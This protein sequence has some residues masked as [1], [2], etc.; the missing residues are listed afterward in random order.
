MLMRKI[1]TLFFLF[2][3]S[4]SFAQPGDTIVITGNCWNTY[5]RSVIIGPTGKVTGLNIQKTDS[6]VFGSRRPW[7]CS[8]R[9]L[10]GNSMPLLI[11]DG[12]QT[13]IKFLSEIN[14]N[15]IKSVEILK[16]AQATAIFGPD[17]ANGALLIQT[18]QSFE[19]K[20]I[21]KDSL[22]GSPIIGATV[23]FISPQNK[24]EK[25][26]YVADDN[27]IVRTDK[28]SSS[29][30]YDIIVSAV[31]YKTA[32]IVFCVGKKK[33]GKA[34]EF[35]LGREIKN[36][37]EVILSST[38]CPRTKRSISCGGWFC[39][40]VSGINITIDSVEKEKIFPTPAKLRIYPNPVQKGSIL[41]FQF[42][43]NEN[44]EKIVRVISLDGRILLQQSFTESGGKNFFQL[45]TDARWSAG[46]YF[47]QLLYENG[48]VA[49]SEKVIIQ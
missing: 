34:V 14:P 42:D 15:Q 19:R 31:G 16:S 27:G 7:C 43:N 30:C 11:I 13:E 26:Q 8:R 4:Y 3:A 48:Q 44:K 5:P 47:V 25:F 46:I 32:E 38:F 35:S 33:S 24:N 36:C 29:H 22:D 9:C 2:I 28:L 17:G 49:A 21:I 6:G 39:C 18:K 37:D 12:V 10:T 40:G 23:S 20:F 1:F 41:N 45:P